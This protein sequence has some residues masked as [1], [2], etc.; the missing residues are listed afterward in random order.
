MAKTSVKVPIC[1]IRRRW[2]ETCSWRKCTNG[3]KLLSDGEGKGKGATSG[4]SGQICG[5]LNCIGSA[6]EASTSTHA[7]IMDTWRGGGEKPPED[8]KSPGH[9]GGFVELRARIRNKFKQVTDEWEWAKNFCK[10]LKE[11]WRSLFSRDQGGV[12]CGTGGWVDGGS[13]MSGSGVSDRGVK[14]GKVRGGGRDVHW[15]WIEVL[16]G[17]H[18][19]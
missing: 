4:G 6:K 15:F 12:R 18:R 2:S 13:Q 7:L 10:A 19:A 3:S 16:C 1:C 5:R 11:G 8:I 9:D 17:G 14:G